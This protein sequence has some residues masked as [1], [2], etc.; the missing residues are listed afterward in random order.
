MSSEEQDWNYRGNYNGQPADP[1]LQVTMA[2]GHQS[3]EH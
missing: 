2:N 3:I 1:W